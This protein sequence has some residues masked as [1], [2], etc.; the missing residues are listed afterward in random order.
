[1]T[2]IEFN[3]NYGTEEQCRQHLFN[4]RWQ[5][6]FIGP[7]C[8]HGEYF[9]IKSRNRYQCKICNHQASVAVGTIIDK[10]KTPLIKWFLAIYLMSE[11]KRGISALALK[12][13]IGVAYQTAWTMC[14]KIRHAMSERDSVNKL[15][16]IVELDE[17]F[18]A[19][20]IRERRSTKQSVGVK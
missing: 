14:H 1:M 9:N 6:G 19:P 11:D 3:A 20:Q 4:N 18:S 15:E 10:S 5:D 2:L 13:K 7:K 8:S 12:G 16:S 17:A